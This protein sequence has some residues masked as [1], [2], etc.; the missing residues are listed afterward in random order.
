M[1]LRHSRARLS[2]QQQL[3]N[4]DSRY[5]EFNFQQFA[6]GTGINY[7]AKCMLEQSFRLRSTFMR[8]LEDNP[9]V[10]PRSSNYLTLRVRINE[11]T[12][13]I[14]EWKINHFPPSQHNTWSIKGDRNWTRA[15]AFGTQQEKLWC[16]SISLKDWRW[17]TRSDIWTPSWIFTF[18]P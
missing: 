17:E 10:L 9:S 3:D 14:T 4:L 6:L 7:V 13:W 2:Q 1:R 11:K 16:S 12:F 5:S 15:E 8:E 18:V